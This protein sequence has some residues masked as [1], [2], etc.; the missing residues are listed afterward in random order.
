MRHSFSILGMCS[1]THIFKNVDISSERSLH[2]LHEILQ[3]SPHLIR[4]IRRLTLR[5][6]GHS[7]QVLAA[8]AFTNLEHAFVHLARQP[9]LEHITALRQ[10]F[11]LPTLRSAGLH[12]GDSEASTWLEIWDHCRSTIQHLRLEASAGKSQLAAGCQAVRLIYRHS[13]API[14]L[15]SLRALRPLWSEDSIGPYL[16][17]NT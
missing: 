17:G 3:H 2:R 10:L 14:R 8:I 11:S 12:C 16:H 1:P 5:V 15:E 13:I 7:L 4:H 9:T 6:P